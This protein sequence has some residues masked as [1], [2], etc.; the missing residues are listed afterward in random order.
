MP[1]QTPEYY[2]HAD[3]VT[4]AG[5]NKLSANLTYLASLRVFNQSR[6]GD[7]RFSNPEQLVMQHRFRYLIYK[8]AD[9]D[10]EPCVLS[11]PWNP[12]GLEHELGFVADDEE[13]SL[14]DLTSIPWLALG[15]VYRITNCLYAFELDVV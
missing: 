11:P 1:F 2:Q 6:G 12:A 8:E 9:D 14:V 10:A 13:Y 5:L 4:A 3:A 7:R 15:M